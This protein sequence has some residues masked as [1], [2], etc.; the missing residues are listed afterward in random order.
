M[1]K[2]KTTD[3]T[4][5]EL[6]KEAAVKLFGRYGYEGTSVRNIA[7]HA[8]VTAGQI[9]LNFGSK[10]NLFNE[11]VMDIYEDA[12]RLYDPIIGEYEFLKRE[13][14]LT[15]ECVWK[16]IEQIID[17]QIAYTFDINNI[18]KTQIINV[19]MFNENVRTSAKLAQLTISKIEDTLAKLLQ[20]VFVQKRYLHARTVS[21]AVNGAIISFAE[22]PELL[23]QEVLGSE[24]M[25][26]AKVWMIEYVKNY[27][28]DSLH[29][30]ALREDV[31][32]G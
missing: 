18:E 12:C 32:N 10:E 30:E 23:L 2:A 17:F 22:H 13:G 7:K 6:L 14:A 26:N 16:L 9:T 5:A 3:K 20:E 4:T 28:M 29:N 1:R 24:Y 25:P 27:I 11:I 8:G 31:G 15:K 21:R 19:H